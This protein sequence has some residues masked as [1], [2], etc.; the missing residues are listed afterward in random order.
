MKVSPST[1]RSASSSIYLSVSSFH[2]QLPLSSDLMITFLWQSLNH[3]CVPHTLLRKALSS[4][5][6]SGNNNERSCFYCNLSLKYQ[7]PFWWVVAL[8][9]NVRSNDRVRV[10]K[11]DRGN[12]FLPSLQVLA[13]CLPSPFL[14]AA[15]HRPSREDL[16]PVGVVCMCS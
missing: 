15:F 2:P 4:P 10:R 9:T 16:F 5:F 8:C 1:L 6:V 7:T 12:G 3:A 13:C 14:Y 11:R